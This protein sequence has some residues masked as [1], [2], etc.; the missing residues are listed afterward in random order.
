MSANADERAGGNVAVVLTPPG[1]AAIAVIR[2]AGP[3]NEAF[4]AAHLSRVPKAGRCVH[5]D[6]RA[7]GDDQ[8]I[9]DLVVVRTPDGRLYRRIEKKPDPDALALLASIAQR[10]SA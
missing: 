10:L 4:A 7:A 2:L 1:I 3:L 6:L 5:A 8:V 9:D